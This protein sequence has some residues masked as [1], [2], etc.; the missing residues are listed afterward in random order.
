M[1]VQEIKVIEGKEYTVLNG[2]FYIDGIVEPNMDRGL[3]LTATS[4]AQGKQK[5][6][7]RNLEEMGIPLHREGDNKVIIDCN[8]LIN[9]GLVCYPIPLDDNASTS[10]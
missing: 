5:S 3:T 1:K 9:G 8:L 4:A 7:M 10:D 2:D 6:Q